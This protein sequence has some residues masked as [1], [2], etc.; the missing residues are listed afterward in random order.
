MLHTTTTTAK[1]AKV[2]QDISQAEVHKYSVSK[3]SQ[4]TQFRKQFLAESILK[5][6][7]SA[8]N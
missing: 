3:N 1:D 8:K 6:T 5:N 4:K 2:I 7:D